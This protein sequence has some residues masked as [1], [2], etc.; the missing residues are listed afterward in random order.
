MI[1]GARV[2]DIAAA[3]GYDRSTVFLWL[4][5]YKMGGMNALVTK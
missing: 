5:K 3:L 4:R 2:D 1:K